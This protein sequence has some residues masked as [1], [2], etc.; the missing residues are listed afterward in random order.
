MYYDKISLVLKTIFNNALNMGTVPDLWQKLNLD[1]KIFIKII[2][3][4]LNHICKDIID[5]HQTEFIKDKSIVD[6]ALDI[7]ST[8]KSQEKQQKLNEAPTGPLSFK[9]TAYENGLTVGI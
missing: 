1:A 5:E 8:I 3:N 2:A 4:R 7:I 6:A 9:I